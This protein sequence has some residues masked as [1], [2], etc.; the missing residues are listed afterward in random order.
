MNRAIGRLGRLA[1]VAVLI[2]AVV[3]LQ[4]R[5]NAALDDNLAATVLTM[6]VS[7]VIVAWVVPIL[8]LPKGGGSPRR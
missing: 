5:L 4:R 2:V 1:V 3:L 8:A 7:I 6:T